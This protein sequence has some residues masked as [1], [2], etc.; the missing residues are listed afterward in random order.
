[1]LHYYD[2][3]KVGSSGKESPRNFAVAAASARLRE[4]SRRPGLREDASWIA[5]IGVEWP[6][7]GAPVVR[8][9]EFLVG[10]AVQSNSPRLKALLEAYPKVLV[11]EMEGIGAGRAF[12]DSSLATQPPEY[13][14]VR[15]VSDF[16]NVDAEHNQRTRDA[17]RD[18][19]AAAA[20]AHAHAIVMEADDS[21]RGTG[22]SADV[23]SD[24][25]PLLQSDAQAGPL[26]PTSAPRMTSRPPGR[27]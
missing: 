9:G 27:H 10:G 16:C 20:A 15:G 8:E 4:W 23:K 18:Y 12:A 7:A 25:G 24:S 6:V 3:H 26:A 1:V 2:S 17:W 11:V 21:H 5:R 19:A 22:N 14:A 13:L